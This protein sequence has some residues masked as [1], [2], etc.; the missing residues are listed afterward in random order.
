MVLRDEQ[1]KFFQFLDWILGDLLAHQTAIIELGDRR[2]QALARR[3]SD[4]FRQRRAGFL[5]RSGGHVIAEPANRGD[6][7]SFN[8]GTQ[9]CIDRAR[10]IVAGQHGQQA[11]GQETLYARRRIRIQRRQQ[12]AQRLGPQTRQRVTEIRRDGILKLRASRHVY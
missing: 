7:K 12:F 2:W 9:N 4:L 3:R 11:P 8:L 10:G 1:H 6:Q 5:D